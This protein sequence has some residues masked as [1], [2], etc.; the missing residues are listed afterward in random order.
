[1]CGITGFLYRSQRPKQAELAQNVERM[2][3]RLRHRGP[4]AGGLWTDA[5]A[6]IA[7]GHRRLSIIDLSEAGAQPMR[8]A[9]G[10]YI[11]AYNGEIYDF[12]STRKELE[13]AGYPFKGHSDTE[14]L[15]AA[16]ERWGL[17]R[18]LDAVHGMFAFA[19]WDREKR[20]LSLARDRVG[21]KP[22][23]YGWC[24]DAFLFASE[25]KALRAHPEFDGLVDR[26]ALGEFVRYGWI[27]EP[28]SIY[29]NIR[30]LR[31]GSFVRIK[32]ESSPW[33]VAVETYWAANQIMTSAKAN[34]FPGSF[35][36]A[37]DRLD[38]LLVQA[39]TERMVADVDLG[40][41]LSGGIDSSTVVG[42]MQRHSER[43]VKTF[44][45]GFGEKKYNEAEYASAIAR[46]LGTD[47]HE[48]YVTPKECLDVVDR[49][50][51]IYD[52]PFSD[53]SQV[54]TFIVA[55]MASQHVKVV[56]SG[57]G[58]DETFSG[59]K[60][61]AEGLA[62]WYW[63]SKLPHGLRRSA[64]DLLTSAGD[65]SWYLC[66]P[67]RAYQSQRLPVWRKFGSKLQRKTRSWRAASPQEVMATHF[68]RT[69]QPESLVIGSS[70]AVSNMSDP[71]V[72]ARNIDPLS[73]M[74]HFDFVGYMVGDILVKVDRA[75]MA[76]SLEARCPILD[77]RITEFSWTLP[78]DYLMDGKSGKK[79]LRAVLE[80]Y[81]PRKFTDRPKRG[82]GVPI[83]TWLQDPLRDWVE[84]LISVQKLREFGYLRPEGVRRLWQQHLCGWRNHSNILWSIVMF[85]AW[86]QGSVSETAE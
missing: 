80:R 8:S 38:E 52:E 73:A 85:Q 16:I 62:Q 9:S 58:G 19:V 81:V 34:P 36:Q 10:R 13:A 84:E 42:I 54:P 39:V 3:N 55:Q 49:L 1:M 67:S 29:E 28:L 51:S 77:N 20:E 22:L 86:Q 60:H 40:A 53:I 56:L 41:L 37:V 64:A 79:I 43:P 66:K 7:L 45:I 46:H 44:A 61:Y 65:S 57:D 14:V 32:A 31:P 15:L 23:Y 48:L 27:S 24:G 59:Y 50:P 47:H 70:P 82:F 18:A 30:K 72:W 63:L 83:D 6:G 25:L 71:Q 2:A 33:A 35:D 78:N 17:Q 69:H 12:A 75:T 76:V 11:I 21:K 26:S 5:Q 74:L 68:S 4:D